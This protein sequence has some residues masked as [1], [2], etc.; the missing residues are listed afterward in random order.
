MATLVHALVNLNCW[1][2]PGVSTLT[3]GDNLNSFC[4]AYDVNSDHR[5]DLADF[6]EL[7]NQGDCLFFAWTFNP[8]GCP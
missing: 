7:Q 4:Q 5:V 1:L 8:E 2:G 6:A 3:Y